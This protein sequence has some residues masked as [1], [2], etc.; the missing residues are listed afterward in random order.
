MLNPKTVIKESNSSVALISVFPI[1]TGTTTVVS[2]YK[3]ALTEL[4]YHVV[5]YQ[6][7]IPDESKKY[8]DSTY[9]IGGKRFFL[10]DL[11]MWLRMKQ[12]ALE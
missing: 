10:K 2:D 12:D 7:V 6:L 8:L 3:D 5:L 9:K 1:H 11:D 4:G